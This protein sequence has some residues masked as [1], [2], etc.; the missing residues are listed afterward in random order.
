MN[1]EGFIRSYSINPVDP[2]KAGT[3]PY[4]IPAIRTGKEISL[5]PQ[6]TFFVGENGTGKSTIIEALAVSAGFNAEGGSKNFAFSTNSTE[7]TLHQALRLV[8][9][10]RRER[11]GFFLRAE[12]FYNVATNIDEL[13]K[14][15][16][17]GPKIIESYG[18]VSLHR[19]S[20]GESFMALV[21]NRFGSNG[22]YILDEPEA[23]LSPTRQLALL[24]NM[25]QLVKEGSQFIIATHSPI[26]LG[27]P[28]AYIY[29][30]S[31]TGIE[32]TRY[33]DTAHYRLTRDFLDNPGL[34]QEKL[35][36]E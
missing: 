27:Y 8:R 35:F 13:D 7:S 30:L 23:A 21:T 20:H 2:E 29:Q 14:E 24:S 15:P 25:H 11:T 4:S 28:G 31:Q 1:T 10:P 6:V 5:S 12:S 22:L 19:Q 36:G 32:R 3:Y 16:G 18:G 17:F 34:Y 33:E 26:L 9:N